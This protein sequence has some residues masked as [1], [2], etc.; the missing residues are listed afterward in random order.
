MNEP[1]VGYVGLDH[2]HAEPYLQTLQT[3]P[4]TVTCAC[5]PNPAFDPSA[6][7]SLGDVP[8]Y[9]NLE[10]LLATESVDAVFL[11]LP[12]RDTPKAI[13]R[14]V[15]AGIHVYTEK[16]AART[17][18][19]L[20]PLLARVEEAESTVCVSY[21]WQSHPIARELATLV[22][23]GFFGDLRAF[24]ARFV[25]SQLA[26]RD[27]S[28]FI[29]DADASRGGILQWLGIH[30]LQLLSWLLEER[31]VRVNASMASGT[32]NVDVED[33]ATLQLETSDGALGTLQCGYY[34][35]DGLY[36]TKIDIYGNDGRSAWDP[37][38]RKFGFQDET[39]LELDDTSGEWESTPHRTVT[40]DYDPEP[41]YG[42][43]WG[44]AFVEK[45]FGACDGER[46]PP[47]TLADAME[48][49]RILDAAY[50]SAEA[51][52]WVD[53]KGANR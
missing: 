47:V 46:E 6:V 28:H 11:T 29:F 33:S 39:A 34:L 41:G 8:V 15:D 38:G 16:P 18:T 23:E 40:H 42:G 7:S 45:F 9:D 32:D 12:N 31:I 50:E 20:E 51:G 27:T 43:A 48:V 21:P 24:D 35:G 26:Y 36:D 5:E 4:A 22:D 30:W 1:T 19:E 14:A 53:V 13:E 37:M 49:L 52:K 3:L 10:T 44:R 2:H 17:A 25:A